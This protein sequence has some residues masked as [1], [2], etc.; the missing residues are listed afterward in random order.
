[1]P[2]SVLSTEKLI[3]AGVLPDDEPFDVGPHAATA[4]AKATKADSLSHK[5]LRLL[6]NAS[7]YSQV[8]HH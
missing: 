8:A 4:K 6:M 3:S 5:G 1:M 2:R 7:S